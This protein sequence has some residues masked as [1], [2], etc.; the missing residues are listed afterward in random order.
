MAKLLLGKASPATT[1]FHTVRDGRESELN[2]MPKTSV[3]VGIVNMN[4]CGHDS[5][6]E[7]TDTT[8]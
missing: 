5:T 3:A 8:Y 1:L 7:V 6:S 2:A 4:M